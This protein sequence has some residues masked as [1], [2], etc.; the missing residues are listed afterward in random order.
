MRKREVHTVHWRLTILLPLVMFA[1]TVHAQS[2]TTIHQA[3]LMEPDQKTQEVSTEE[4]QRILE[5]RTSVVF[6]VRPPQEF[7]VSH[8]PGAMNVSP[9]PGVSIA[10]YFSDIA[11]I[12]HCS[13]ATRAVPIVLYCNGPH[14]GKSKRVTTELLEARL[15]ERRRY[16]LGV[17]VWRA[18]VGVAQVEPNGIRRIVAV[19]DRTARAS[20]D[21]RDDC[22]RLRAEASPMRR[23]CRAVG[24]AGQDV[25]GVE[26]REGRRA[27]LCRWRI[28]HA[29]IVSERRP[30]GARRR[31]RAI[32][33]E[34]FHDMSF[35]DGS[36]DQF[37]A[38]CA[39]SAVVTTSPRSLRAARGARHARRTRPIRSRR[40]RACCRG[41]RVGAG[42]RSSAR[43]GVIVREPRDEAA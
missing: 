39:T 18:F 19:P 26:A 43:R 8:I 21:A 25:G 41:C 30:T 35:F 23:A 36:V 4:L 32:A 24:R 34:A 7:A 3:T 20:I 5:D 38:G 17:H 2:S 15:H 10:L 9:K 28:T 6:D 31:G 29:I 12:G 16:R 11:E 37:K 27:A 22:R 40:C 33:K 13:R 42:V 14:S 1:A